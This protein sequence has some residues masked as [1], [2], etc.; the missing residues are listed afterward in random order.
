MNPRIKEIL[1][2]SIF[3]KQ[4]ILQDQKLLDT[5]QKIVDVTIIA[6]KADRKILFCGNG[7]SAADAQHLASE[8]SG[9]FY[10]DRPAL[11]AEALH[12]NSSA[13]TSIGNDFGFDQI[14]S[15]QI[16]AKGRQGD[17]LYALSTSGNSPNVLRAIEA[18]KKKFMV[19]VGMTNAKGGKMANNC[20][21]ILKVPTIDTPRCQ[22]AHI[23]MG[24]IICELVESAIYN[25]NGS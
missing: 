2:E 22:E 25:S 14:F 3:V 4:S 16:E 18:A 17:V 11:F 7:G 10:L 15:R 19:V 13:T 12:V 9:K 23:V 1:S 6:L 5:L 21:Y 20:D 8:L 24:H